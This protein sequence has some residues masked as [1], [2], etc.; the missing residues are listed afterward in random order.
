S[1]TS[2]S[3]TPPTPP[4]SP[5]SPAASTSSGPAPAPPVRTRAPDMTRFPV[6]WT[7]Q[8]IRRAA[9][10]TAAPLV[11]LVAALGM[12]VAPAPA[13]RAGNGCRGGDPLANV[14]DPKRLEVFDR[15]VTASG[16]VHRTRSEADGDI[17]VFLR[18]D[19]G[20]AHLTN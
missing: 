13:S 10:A 7:V 5:P 11:I 19:R 6:E 16:V 14:R 8:R 1:T 20:S 18:P 3:T 17:D 15:C 12:V 2:S 9:W 4:T